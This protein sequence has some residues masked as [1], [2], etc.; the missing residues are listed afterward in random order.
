MKNLLLK[1]Q[2]IDKSRKAILLII[3]F[4]IINYPFN[5]HCN[6]QEGQVSDPQGDSIIIKS[7]RLIADNYVF[8]EI[9]N[10]ISGKL[11]NDL[12]LGV[13]EETSTLESLT[14][15]LQGQIWE[16]SK[17]RHFR[18]GTIGSGQ[19]EDD[20]G[21]I[22]YSE[23][24]FKTI[25]TIDDSIVYFE[26]DHLPGGKDDLNYI[27]EVMSENLFCKAM[28]FDVRNNIGG[29]GDFVTFLCSYLF[30]DHILLC[31]F[32]NRD[33]EIVSRSITNPP[34]LMK[35]TPLAKTPVYVLT[36]HETRS[37]AESLAYTLKYFN[38][39]VIVGEVTAGMAHP[40]KTLRID[41]SVYL[42]IP[43]IRFEHPNTGTDWEGTGVIPDVEV[44]QDQALEKTLQLIRDINN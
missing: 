6:A 17:D 31:T 16:I 11:L 18:I 43:F 5:N 7:A 15:I 35:I 2:F 33:G 24:G 3:L 19:N 42:T 38:R 36:G 14:G 21:K 40:A 41:R 37:A 4:S 30:N 10:S 23:H 9:G 44:P 13:Y 29:S 26:F 25:R 27:R 22:S 32:H 20:G 8:K 1:A 34:D 28:I 39:A 12:R